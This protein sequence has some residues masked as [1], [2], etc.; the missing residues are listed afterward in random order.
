MKA[1]GIWGANRAWL[2]LSIGWIGTKL[3]QLINRMDWNKKL[4]MHCLM[5]T[6]RAPPTQE[7][8]RAGWLGGLNKEMEDVCSS[9]AGPN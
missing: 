7:A 6:R 4:Y 8:Q 3:G 2:N 5:E 9:P 1:T